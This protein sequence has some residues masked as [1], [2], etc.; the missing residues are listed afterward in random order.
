MSATTHAIDI[1]Y[2]EAA[3]L[4]LK[5]TVGA[6]KLSLEPGEEASWIQGTYSDP[7]G[8]LPLRVQQEGGQV[9][10]SQSPSLG[11][12]LR[13]PTS[14]P[15]LELRLGTGRAYSLSL[16][17]GAS[18][19]ELDLGGLPLRRLEIKQGA[20]KMEVDFSRPN[21]EPMS[22]LR[23]TSGA[24]GLEIDHLA[25]ANF[26]E[27]TVEGGAAA[28]RFDF[29]GRLQRAGHAR[30]TASAASVEIH[31]PSDV[32]ARIIAELT[33]ST[34]D[35]GDGFTKKEG[36][37]WTPRALKDAEPALL[38]EVALSVGVLRLRTD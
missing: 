3:D 2:P 31:V 37:F 7:T 18:D 35:L 13:L 6:C 27:M 17:T 25:N 29:D 10:I 36:A 24:A 20:G 4:H 22:L 14:V 12:L 1:P 19:S 21:P 38:I 23:L 34:L 26:A 15:R 16:E 32:A 30:I 5:L 11:E 8:T 33:V 28:Y 9:K